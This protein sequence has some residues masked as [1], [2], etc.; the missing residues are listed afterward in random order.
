[1]KPIQPEVTDK[2][3]VRVTRDS[4]KVQIGAMTPSFPPARVPPQ[5]SKDN[6]GGQ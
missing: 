3:H 1:M 6:E 4:A 2:L 5:V